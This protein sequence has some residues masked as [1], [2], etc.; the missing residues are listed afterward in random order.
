MNNDREEKKSIYKKWWF[1][2]TILVIAVG[3][4][5]TTTIIIAV[6]NKTNE[7]DEIALEIQKLNSKAT[8]YTSSTKKNII[9][10]IPNYS[11][12]CKYTKCNKRSNKK[13]TERK[14]KNIFKFYNGI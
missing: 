3:I 1:W 7:M 14:L 10:E 11:N 8:I 9:V 5:F 13:W 2:L 12:W 4:I 6:F